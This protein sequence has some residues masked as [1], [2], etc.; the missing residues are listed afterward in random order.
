M[1]LRISTQKFT[2]RFPKNGQNH[3][4]GKSD[5]RTSNLH[6]GES[7]FVLSGERHTS[8]AVHTHLTW[9]F[10]LCVIWASWGEFFLFN[11]RISTG[12]PRRALLTLAGDGPARRTMGLARW[13]CMTV[14]KTFKCPTLCWKVTEKIGTLITA[15]LL[16]PDKGLN[17]AWKITWRR[18]PVGFTFNQRPQ[19]Q[20]QSPPTCWETLRERCLTVAVLLDG[21]RHL[22]QSHIGKRYCCVPGYTDNHLVNA[23]QNRHSDK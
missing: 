2:T 22:W 1:L 15:A 16:Q 14:L 10:L 8:A 18:K 9:L 20:H 19:A 12:Q 11:W 23:I 3:L 5:I 7:K 17:W 6:L 13:K 21:W 4:K